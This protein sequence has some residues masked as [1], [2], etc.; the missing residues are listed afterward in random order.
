MYDPNNEPRTKEEVQKMIDHFYKF[1]EL[2]RTQMNS[3][4]DF[5]PLSH[6]EFSLIMRTLDRLNTDRKE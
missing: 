4:Y 6:N 2:I 3:L 1:G 5:V